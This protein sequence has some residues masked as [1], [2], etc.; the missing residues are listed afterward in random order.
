MQKQIEYKLM[1][2]FR[3]PNFRNYSDGFLQ[4]NNHRS[5]E[6]NSSSLRLVYVKMRKSQIVVL[7]QLLLRL[8]NKTA[9]STYTLPIAFYFKIQGYSISLQGNTRKSLLATEPITHIINKT[10]Y[11]SIDSS[12]LLP[13]IAV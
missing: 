11:K 3:S 6:I 7:F 8:L 2:I 1:H 13:Q 12:G 10:A 5:K 9:V 4:G